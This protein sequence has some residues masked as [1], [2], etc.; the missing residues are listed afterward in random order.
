VDCRP[1]PREGKS[2]FK[3]RAL[4]GHRANLQAALNG[5]QPISH[6]LQPGSTL[7]SLHCKT[8]AVIRHLEYQLIRLGIQSDTHGGLRGVSGAVLQRLERAEVGSFIRNSLVGA[9]GEELGWRGFLF[10]ELQRIT[11]FT[12]AS[13]IGGVVWALHHLPLILFSDYHSTAPIA[14][15]VVVFFISTIVL[16]FVYNWLRVRSGS[17][18][19]AVVLHASHNIFFS[20]VYDPLMERYA[21][22]EATNRSS[23][24]S[25][26][27]V[28]WN[29]LRT[30]RASNS[31]SNKPNTPLR[32]SYST[33]SR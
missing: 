2:P 7:R 3:G 13:V 11:S 20:N 12:T 16:T 29:A 9:L 31:R 24:S 18:W 15:Q 21:L 8:G 4:S 5:G 23:R 19:P 14:F 25:E 27:N 30:P 32:G 22:T 1:I 10:P 17:V 28:F 6:A 26:V 33:T